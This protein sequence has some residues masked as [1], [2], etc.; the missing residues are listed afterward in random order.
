YSGSAPLTAATPDSFLAEQLGGT[1]PLSDTIFS[2]WNLI[3]LA[4]FLAVLAACYAL[5]APKK[6]D[7]VHEMPEHQM[8]DDSISYDVE[9]PYDRLDARRLVTLVPGLLMALYLVLHFRDGGTLTLDIV[10]WT[11]LTLGLLLVGNPFVLIEL[12]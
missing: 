2:A 6:G 4:V 9:T 12:T 3:I 7:P 5:L 8:E 11:F 1:I 10:N